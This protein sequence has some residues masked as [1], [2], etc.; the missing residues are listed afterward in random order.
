MKKKL[1]P[2]LIIIF[3][4]YLIVS[5]SREI[6]ELIQKEKIIG[7]EQLKLEEL[8]VENQVLREQLNYVQSE[9]FVEKEAREKL[10]MNK[11]GEIVVIL[12]EDFEEMVEQSQ[13]A[14]E[15]EEIPNWKQ[16]LG[17][18]GFN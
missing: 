13:G 2:S 11:E 18:F 3:S 1:I 16:W 15:P 6:F 8:K 12:P 17:L 9:G 14:V 10:G 7:K 4:L 5:L